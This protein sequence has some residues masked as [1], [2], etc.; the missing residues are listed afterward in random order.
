M[1]TW[2]SR[3]SVPTVR[4]IG[5]VEFVGATGLILPL[6]LNIVP[7]F[8]IFAAGGIA[9][10]MILASIHHIDHR[11]YKPVFLTLTLL[12]LAVFITYARIEMLL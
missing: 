7:Y 3:F 6:V 2:T 10:V 12:M 4:F 11:E 5:I 1:A 9:L 8:E